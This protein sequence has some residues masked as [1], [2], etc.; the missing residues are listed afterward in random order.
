MENV[1]VN[2]TTQ[3]CSPGE[4]LTT[5]EDDIQGKVLGKYNLSFLRDVS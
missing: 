2:D 5:L 3:N 1:A 4:N